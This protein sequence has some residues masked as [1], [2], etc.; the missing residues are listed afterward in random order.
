[1]HHQAR[2]RWCYIMKIAGDAMICNA[3]C[4]KAITALSKTLTFAKEITGPVMA[5]LRG[6]KCQTR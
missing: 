2:N 3:T 5:Q 4:V 6:A 1:M